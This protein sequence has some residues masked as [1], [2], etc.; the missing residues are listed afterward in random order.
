MSHI[1]PGWD[2]Y[3]L[4][5]ADAVS[6]RGECVRSQVGAVLVRKDSIDGLPRIVSTGY[7]GV[8]AGA[9]SC[10]DGA[11]PR[12]RNNVPPGTRYDPGTPGECIAHHAER[13]AVIDAS[14]RGLDVAWDTTL[15]VSKE[16]CEQCA[17]FLQSVGI[18]HVVWRAGSASP[19]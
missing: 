10:L 15:Y 9:R 7:N 3:F 12:S 18:E 2:D 17:A 1:R 16:P 11:C 6:V 14:R 5:I 13:N 4:G 19:T 8:E